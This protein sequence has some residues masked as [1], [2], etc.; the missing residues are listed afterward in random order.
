MSL[1]VAIGISSFNLKN[2]RSKVSASLAKELWWWRKPGKD[3]K[4]IP[5]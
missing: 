4:L 3:A 2:C 1:P 5:T